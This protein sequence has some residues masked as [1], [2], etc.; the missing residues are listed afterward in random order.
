MGKL[1]ESLQSQVELLKKEYEYEKD[2][3][4]ENLKSAPLTGR[5]ADGDCWFPIRLG[6][7]CYNATN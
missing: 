5:S 4:L 6:N 2:S 3:Y 7:S 1:F